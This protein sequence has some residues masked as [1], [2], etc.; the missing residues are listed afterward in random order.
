MS[1]KEIIEYLKTNKAIRANLQ[2]S[3]ILNILARV[4]IQKGWFTEEE[5][6]EAVEKSLDIVAKEII[7]NMSL[8]ERNTIESQIKISKNDLFGSLFNNMI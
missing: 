2:I 6:N 4:M 3:A 8:E 1:D 5:F 7:N